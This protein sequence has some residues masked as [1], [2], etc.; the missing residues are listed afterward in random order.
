MAGVFLGSQSLLVMI[1]DE[2]LL[3][4]IATVKSPD[5]KFRYQAVSLLRH[6]AAKGIPISLPRR[7]HFSL[8]GRSPCETAD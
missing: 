2:F 8:S 7:R 6:L 4:V 3:D 1:E 5:S